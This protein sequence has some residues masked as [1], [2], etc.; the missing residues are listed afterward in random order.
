MK[1]SADIMKKISSIMMLNK[2]V[3]GADTRFATTEVPLA[4]NMLGNGLECSE[5]GPTKKRW[6]IAGGNT[7]QCL[8]YGQI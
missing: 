3:D 4:N 8:I 7:N 5:E 1:E 2:H 6:K